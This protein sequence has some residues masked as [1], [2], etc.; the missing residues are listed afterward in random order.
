MD[1]TSSPQFN[2]G[3]IKRGAQIG[4]A[5]WSLIAICRMVLSILIPQPHRGDR[6]GLQPGTLVFILKKEGYFRPKEGEKETGP[7]R[8]R[9]AQKEGDLTG[10]Y[11][12]PK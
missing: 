3:T 5:R 2:V 8:G 7:K 10:K 6:E 4:V 11:R 12:C 1:V 9:L